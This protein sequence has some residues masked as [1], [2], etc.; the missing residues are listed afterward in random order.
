MQALHF[1][2]GQGDFPEPT[3]G[4]LSDTRHTDMEASTLYCSDQMITIRERWVILDIRHL[5]RGIDIDMDGTRCAR[6]RTFDDERP[7]ASQ[8]VNG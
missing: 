5:Y 4:C 1:S 2:H 6:E 3:H 7:T 8:V